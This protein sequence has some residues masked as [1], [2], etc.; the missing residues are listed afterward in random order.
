[1]ESGHKLMVDNV[2]LHV[3]MSKFKTSA[4]TGGDRLCYCIMAT[5]AGLRLG[6]EIDQLSV[7]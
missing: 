1:M 4:S 6:G 7:N 5:S 3:S 2:D